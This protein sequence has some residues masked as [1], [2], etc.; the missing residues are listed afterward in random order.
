[1]TDRDGVLGS[2]RASE[3]KG[4]AV[5]QIGGVEADAVHAEPEQC[6]VAA[7][8]RAAVVA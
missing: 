7:G 1:M 5:G 6:R 8:P 4:V 3:A 2:V